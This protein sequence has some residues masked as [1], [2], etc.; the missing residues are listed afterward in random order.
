MTELA[1][2][3]APEPAPLGYS[4]ALKTQAEQ[5]ADLRRMRAIATMLLV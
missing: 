5:R 3:A 2:P 4:D 1:R